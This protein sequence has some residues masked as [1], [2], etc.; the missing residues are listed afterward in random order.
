GQ[1]L[2]IDLQYSSAQAEAKPVVQFEFTT[3]PA[4]SAATITS[5]SAHVKLDGVSQGAD[6]TYSVPTGGLTDGATYNIPLQVDATG[7]ATGVYP[8]SL[9]ATEVFNDGTSA[10]TVATG[11]V[12]IV[13]ASSDALGAGWSIG[14]LQQIS[15]P[16]ANGAV[17]ITAGQND[18]E[19]FNEV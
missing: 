1:K 11:E 14:S 8:Y 19:Q 7:L 6:T 4:G 18:V 16:N 5:I 10:S 3:P 12:Q 13:N 15:A 2:G 9:T 17:L